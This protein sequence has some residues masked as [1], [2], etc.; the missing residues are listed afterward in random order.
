[1]SSFVTRY[2]Q[3]LYIQSYIGIQYATM[4]ACVGLYRA[5]DN[6]YDFF[7]PI[8]RVIGKNGAYFKYTTNMGNMTI[9]S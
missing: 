4:Y 8:Y 5:S 3:I 6:N 1:M 9:L 2:I 7:T